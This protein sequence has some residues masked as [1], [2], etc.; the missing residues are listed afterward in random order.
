MRRN[1]EYEYKISS[2]KSQILEFEIYSLFKIVYLNSVVYSNVKLNLFL[3]IFFKI[4][5]YIL[6]ISKYIFQKPMFETA[7]H[8]FKVNRCSERTFVVI[9]FFNFVTP[10][11]HAA[12]Q[13]CSL[14]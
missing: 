10:K 2:L 13:S 12:F 8:C 6:P 5:N 4:Q 11:W 7:S 9:A 14:P 3:V 1:F